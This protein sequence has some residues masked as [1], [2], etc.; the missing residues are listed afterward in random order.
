[1]RL[2]TAEGVLTWAG[3]ASLS[4]GSLHWAHCICTGKSIWK[5]GDERQTGFEEGSSSWGTHLHSCRCWEFWNTKDDHRTATCE[6]K[7]KFYKSLL[8]CS[9][10][11]Y[12]P[13]LYPQNYVRCRNTFTQCTVSFYICKCLLEYLP[14]EQVLAK[15]LA[16]D[17]CN[18]LALHGEGAKMH[19]SCQGAH[20]SAV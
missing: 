5:L 8:L 19:T 2:H 4:R 20:L 11:L 7:I 12:P 14:E 15:G 3:Q 18:L 9:P 6:P 16:A 1:M 10:C 13:C 17:F